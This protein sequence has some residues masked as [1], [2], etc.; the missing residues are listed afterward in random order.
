MTATN[1]WFYGVM[2]C[3]Y[4]KKRFFSFACVC[5]TESTTVNCNDFDQSAFPRCLLC[6][7]PLEKNRK[8]EFLYARG[9][10]EAAVQMSTTSAAHR[11]MKRKFQPI[12]N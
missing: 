12:R 11:G 1:A 4:V 8:R 10:W 5:F 2:K 7:D 3:V 9:A 6:H